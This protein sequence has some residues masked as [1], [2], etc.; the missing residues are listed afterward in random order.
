MAYLDRL[1]RR[2]GRR[3]CAPRWPRLAGAAG[4]LR[5]G[6]AVPALDRPVPQGRPAG[7]RR[8]CRSPARVERDLACPAGRSPSAGCRWR[9]RSA[10][11]RRSPSRIA[12]V[13]A[14]APAPTARA[15]RRASCSP[16]RRGH[17][18][19]ARRSHCAGIRGNP[20][21]DPRD[22]RL[23]RVPEPCALVVFGVTGDLARKK[24]IPAIYDLANRGLLPPGFVAA[25]LRPP[26]LGRR[27]LRDAGPQGR[28]RSTP[29]PPFRDEVWARLADSI[30][31]VPGLVRRRRRVRHAR[32]RRWSSCEDDARHPGQRRVLPVDPA[33]GVPGRAQADAAHRDGR[34]RRVAAAGAGSSSRSRSG[35]T[36]E[37]ARELNE[38][39]DDVFT[40]AG[41]LPDRPLPRQGD[42][43]EPAGAA[44]RQHAVRAG[45]E[46][47]TSSTRCRSRWPRT[48]A[49]ARRAG[50]YDTAGA[51]RDVLQ[52]HLLQLLAL[53]AMEEP[54]ALRRRGDPDREDSRCCGA[55]SLPADLDRYASAASTTR[56]GSAGERVAGLPRREGHPEGLDDRDL[57]RGTP[58]RRDPPLGRRAVLPAHRQA[59]APP[60]HRDR[61]GVQEGAAP[62]VRR[63]R[64]RGA[65][66]QPARRS[67]CSPTRASRCGSARRC[68]ARRWRSATSSMDFLYGEAF[69]ESSPGGVRAADPRRAARRRD[70]VPAQRGGRGRPGRSSTRSRSSG[71]ARKPELY[72]AGEWGPRGRRRDARPRRPGLE[73]AMRSGHA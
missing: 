33:G 56:A 27:R 53:T 38:L 49:S 13:A 72:R 21:R 8:S 42:G 36:C 60:G 4:H 41:R 20:L 18:V 9:R 11:C 58:R 52:N 29:A 2:V 39:V 26:R 47:A 57:R 6:A 19:T 14:A 22:R 40:A 35:T 46:L 24:L 61:G 23:P 5:L 64:H 55:I 62:A 65:R 34:Q 67:G 43:P 7:R 15:G 66:P 44:V 1:A 48:S 16:P 71:P 12:P 28:R 59:A 25:R 54:V 37:S 68:R 17:G 69:T 45:L 70:A 30:Q 31:F 63:D 32:P 3:R 51:A 73:A 10:T 50:F